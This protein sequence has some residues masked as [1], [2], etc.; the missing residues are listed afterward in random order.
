MPIG[1]ASRT[2]WCPSC[3]RKSADYYIVCILGVIQTQVPVVIRASESASV[4]LSE[5]WHTLT[6]AK[7]QDR[8]PC[9]NRLV[10]HLRDFFCQLTH[11]L[12]TRD[13]AILILADHAR[14]G[15]RVHEHRHGRA[16][17]GKFKIASAGGIL[18]CVSWRK[19]SAFQSIRQV[20][21]WMK[22]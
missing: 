12:P 9:K 16:D 22:P 14:L 20:K 5:E 13:A 10:C 19:K 18:R 6:T 15:Q 21:V 17:G 8:N 2:N 4:S 3:R 1:T 11:S 7:N